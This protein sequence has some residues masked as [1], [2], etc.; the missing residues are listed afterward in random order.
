MTHHYTNLHYLLNNYFNLSEFTQTIV[1]EYNW[2]KEYSKYKKAYVNVCDCCLENTQI[3]M[4]NTEDDAN[5]GWQYN[6]CIDCF[7]Y[8]KSL[9]MGRYIIHRG[10]CWFVCG[11]IHHGRKCS[12]CRKAGGKYLDLYKSRCKNI[13]AEC[14]EGLPQFDSLQDD[15]ES[16]SD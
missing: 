9:G 6:L 8:G 3:R 4:C 1:R 10:K 14:N 2:F 12:R 7:M 16:Y 5:Y 13:C 15:P 11:I